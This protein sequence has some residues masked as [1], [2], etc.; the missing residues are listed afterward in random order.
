MNTWLYRRCGLYRS[1]F[2][3][4][5]LTRQVYR[6]INRNRRY[7]QK[8]MKVAADIFEDEMK[9]GNFSSAL[10]SAAFY[11]DAYIKLHN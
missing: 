5:L 1:Q 11:I 6:K 3:E 9:A 8:Q 4:E 10:D 2:A 7:L